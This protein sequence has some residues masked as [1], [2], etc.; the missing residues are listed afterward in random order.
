MPCSANDE[1]VQGFLFGIPLDRARGTAYKTH[2]S[3]QIAQ[4]E[5]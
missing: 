2:G 3:Y 5:P 4:N 1:P